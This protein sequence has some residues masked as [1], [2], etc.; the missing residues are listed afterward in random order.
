MLWRGCLNKDLANCKSSHPTRRALKQSRWLHRKLHPRLPPLASM[1]QVQRGPRTSPELH[2]R[3]RRAKPQQQRLWRAAGP[4]PQRWSC[5]GTPRRGTV[6]GCPRP[7]SRLPDVFA[8]DSGNLQAHLPA[9]HLTRPQAKHHHPLRRRRPVL[10]GA[11]RS[12]PTLETSME[13]PYLIC[14]PH[15]P[16]FVNCLLQTCH[17]QKVAVGEATAP[18]APARCVETS[19]ARHLWSEATSFEQ[20]GGPGRPRQ[21]SESARRWRCA[22][23]CRLSTVLGTAVEQS[24]RP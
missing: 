10:D 4:G 17:R 12:E 7:L 18:T 8:Q 24:S 22:R 11:L 19:C 23:C 21:A 5:E 13:T 16:C 20:L 3:P 9:L 14:F 6:L 15:D 1:W 2:C